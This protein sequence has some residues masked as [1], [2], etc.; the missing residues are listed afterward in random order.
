MQQVLH[1]KK[2]V[3]FTGSAGTGKSVLLR[4][5]IENLKE[6][7]KPGQV[8][9]TAS[10]GIA[11]CNIGGCTLHAFA[12]I[13]LGNGTVDQL[14]V[15]LDENKRAKARW[16]KTKVLI[17]D[18]ISMIDGDLFDKLDEIARRVKR[19]TKPFGGIQLIITGDFY[20][21]PPV[22][23]ACPVQQKQL[24]TATTP[25]GSSITTFTQPT[26]R[27]RASKSGSRSTTTVIKAGSSLHSQATA[28]AM[29]WGELPP[30]E[31][32]HDGN[33]S[34][35]IPEDAVVT[36]GAGADAIQLPTLCFDAKAWKEAIPFTLQLTEVF[37][38][39]D[40]AFIKMLTEMRHG[41]LSEETC[42]VFRKLA[43]EPE[44]PTDED[45]IVATELFALKS[46][47]E[48][49]NRRRL[50]QLPGPMY[51]YQPQDSGPLEKFMDR[52]SNAPTKLQI[53]Q[54]AQVMLIKNLTP[55]LVNGSMG[56]VVGFQKEMSFCEESGE[57]MESHFPVVR[58]IGEEDDL[59]IKPQEWRME[60]PDGEVIGSR[61]QV[62]LILAWAM[63]IHKSQGQTME[64]LKVDMGKIFEA[65]QAYVAL[66]RATS[67]EGLQ[68][69][70]FDKRAVQCDERVEA[71]YNGLNTVQELMQ[72]TAE[73]AG[74]EKGKGSGKV[75]KRKTANSSAAGAAASTAAKRKSTRKIAASTV[76][77][78][79]SE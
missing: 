6:H 46:Q 55:T 22:A 63:S 77:A 71:F 43:R 23:G 31:H 48:Q 1:N 29:E 26:S 65:G 61:I 75:T 14:M 54:N 59:V 64:R 66:S 24:P 79:A 12:G 52:F 40:P 44:Y 17:I 67:L 10:T 72:E 45:G 30:F 19:S 33:N 18:E 36:S 7:Y 34:P 37:R 60:L 32:D 76:T 73:S 47:V 78:A 35:F 28:E 9:V 15:K 27:T 57:W 56:M 53:K 41:K 51:T 4:Q 16:R 62:P 68:V 49:A 8:A 69:L 74:S 2:S 58:F 50:T 25:Y 11:A 39:R 5:L 70:N 20:Q 21:L 38:Q 42:E 3:F 13:G